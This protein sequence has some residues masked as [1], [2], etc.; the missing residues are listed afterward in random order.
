M[1]NPQ[2]RPID[3]RPLARAAIH[4]FLACAKLIDALDE[5]GGLDCCACPDCSDARGA[6]WSLKILGADIEGRILLSEA[7]RR[8]RRIAHAKECRSIGRC[9][10]GPSLSP[11]LVAAEIGRAN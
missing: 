11:E 5:H 1:A 7:L 9:E 2:Q 3:A 10:Q 4:I 6:L 8:A